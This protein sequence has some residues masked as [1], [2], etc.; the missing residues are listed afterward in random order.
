RGAEE[1]DELGAAA[2]GA[3]HQRAPEKRWAESMT[4]LVHGVAATE[5]VQAASR[6]LF[7]R[8]EEGV[9]GSLDE[10]TLAAAL[11]DAGAVSVEPGEPSG[12]ID[13]L[14]ATGLSESR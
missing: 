9:R 3:P 11:E 8:G 14:V 10:S 1:A 12:I 2:R 4:T 5:S 6:A 7:G 13:L